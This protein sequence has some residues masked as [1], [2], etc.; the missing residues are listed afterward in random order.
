[1]RKVTLNIFTILQI[2]LLGGNDTVAV[3]L[4]WA[5][6]SLLNNP[7]VLKKAKEGVDANFQDQILDEDN[8]AKLPYL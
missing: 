3:T 4:E 8:I 2:I 1:M 7:H 5:M 6:T